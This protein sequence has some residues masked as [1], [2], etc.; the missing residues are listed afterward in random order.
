MR[1]WQII[2]L[3]SALG[4]IGGGA[5]Y[6]YA[7]AFDDRDTSNLTT[8]MDGSALELS[9]A[10]TGNDY[11]KGVTNGVGIYSN[12]TLRLSVDDNETCSRGNPIELSSDCAGNDFVQTG[13]NAV[14]LHQ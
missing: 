7:L 8:C 5:L 9:S 2:I 3:G 4:L 13:T 14:D 10:C 11:V 1:L 6:R 12:D